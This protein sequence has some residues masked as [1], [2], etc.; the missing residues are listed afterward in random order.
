MASN[1][2]YGLRR[3]GT[4]ELELPGELLFLIA[5]EDLM[6]RSRREV[7]IVRNRLLDNFITF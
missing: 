5:S 3:L 4:D 7:T 1:D 6:L 2:G